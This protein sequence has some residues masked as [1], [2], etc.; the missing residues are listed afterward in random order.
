MLE[1][2]DG[3]SALVRA[4]MD[5]GCDFF[6]GYP[7]TPATSILLEA[8]RELPQQGGVAVQAEDEIASI[9]M[10]IAAAMAGRKVLTATSGPG[11]SLYSESIGLAVMGEVPMVIVDT[12]R[13]GPATGGATSTADG[14]VQFARWGTAGGYPVL[15]LAPSDVQSTYT[16]TRHA[17]NLSERYRLPVLILSS[18]E[19]AQTRQ[20]VDL[21]RDSAMPVINR[22]PHDQST[23]Y[24]PYRIDD[25][26]DIPAFSP[27]GGTHQVRFT[28]SVH[29]ERGVI[30]AERSTIDAKLRHLDRKIAAAIDELAL[31]DSDIDGE[32]SDLVI[33]YGAAAMAATDAVEQLR[34]G[35]HRV[36]LLVLY[37]LWPV[38]ERAIRAAA[39][40]HTRVVIPEHNLGQYAREIERVLPAHDVARINRIDGDLIMPGKIVE[41]LV[42]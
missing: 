28:T 27:I 38:P 12:Q 3:N 18:K 25:P 11:M 20:T 17:F 4:A 26:A 39:D 33:A 42:S 5:S 23:P 31:V 40:G 35:G 10:C 32:A 21:E 22:R 1:F 19:I 41:E 37:T 29:D 30:T 7:I 14:D 2:I 13:M 34:A 16:I 9:G 24:L 15:V 36:S 8:V 6:A